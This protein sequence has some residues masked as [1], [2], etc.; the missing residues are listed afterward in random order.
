MVKNEEATVAYMQDY[1]QVYFFDEANNRNKNNEYRNKD[2][3]TA[4]IHEM[5][6]LNTKTNTVMNAI[7]AFKNNLFMAIEVLEDNLQQMEK[8][9]QSTK[10][11]GQKGQKTEHN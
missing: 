9:E 2:N 4:L 3:L 10:M 6:T 8:K 5:K 7:G 11:S 1:S